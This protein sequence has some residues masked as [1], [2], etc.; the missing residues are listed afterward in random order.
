MTKEELEIRAILIRANAVR[1]EVGY[2]GTST[3]L[4][5]DAL[6]MFVARYLVAKVERAEEHVGKQ[7]ADRK[8]GRE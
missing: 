5:T 7:L 6:C 8:A 2:E 4:L 1:E 3:D